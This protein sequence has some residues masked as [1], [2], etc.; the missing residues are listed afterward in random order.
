MD[1]F[2][3]AFVQSHFIGNKGLTTK[4]RVKANLYACIAIYHKQR[5]FGVTKAW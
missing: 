2:Q 4:G 1:G 5:K 3:Y